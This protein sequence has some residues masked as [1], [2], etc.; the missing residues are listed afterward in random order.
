MLM[1]AAEYRESLRRYQ[2][3]VFI[4]GRQVDSV[5]DEPL[6][7][8]GIAAVGVTYDFACNPGHA[9]LL[10]AT[11]GTSGKQVNRM[12]HINQ[13]ATDLLHKLEAV[14]LVCAES[15]CAQRYLS[16]DGLNALFQSTQL[17]DANHE[18]RKSVV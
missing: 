18:D 16:Q 7:A 13:S 17:T 9:A 5:A 1:T 2:P 14:R 12:L 6:L 3:R 11:Q 15:G 8:P 4:N 10:T